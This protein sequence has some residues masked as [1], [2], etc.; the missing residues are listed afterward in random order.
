MTTF[1]RALGALLAVLLVAGCDSGPEDGLAPTPVPAAAFAFDS[2]FPQS[3]SLA[4]LDPAQASADPSGA[5]GFN[6]LNAAL[7]VVIVNTAVGAN[8]VLP[9]AITEAVTQNEPS[10]VD[11]VWIWNGTTRVGDWNVNARLEGEI[12]GDGEEAA[13]DLFLSGAN[14]TTGE[15]YS[16]RRLYSARAALDGSEGSWQLFYDI[17]GVSTEV[18][19]ATFVVRAEDDREITFRVPQSN[20]DTEARGASVRYAADGTR[21]VFDWQETTATQ[22][23][24]VEWTDPAGAGFIEAWNYN[25]GQ[26]A[27]WD[28]SLNDVA[29]T[30]S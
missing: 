28:A 1:S 10:I 12:V 21:R 18:L 19:N 26:R 15:S 3:A 2:S 20:P 17:D 9:T 14:V 24:L 29:C 6:F 7:R 5:F 22:T 25:N 4:E 11:G 23:H 27:C 13:W 30:P 8:L 16:D